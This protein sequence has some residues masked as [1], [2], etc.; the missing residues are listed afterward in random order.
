MPISVWCPHI[1]IDFTQTL[2]CCVQFA[3]SFFFTL[4]H[5]IAI[6]YIQNS[7]LTK[8]NQSCVVF[9][10]YQIVCITFGLCCIYVLLIRVK[11]E[12]TKYCMELCNYSILDSNSNLLCA[13]CAEVYCKIH[14]VRIL[15]ILYMHANL[16]TNRSA[17][18]HA[19][20]L[21]FI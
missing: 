10:C 20:L 9:L 7:Y 16:Y 1:D 21:V 17:Y 18:T 19:L 4:F 12:T 11:G 3:H 15:L 2:L 6:K 5:R 13:S 14:A 8:L